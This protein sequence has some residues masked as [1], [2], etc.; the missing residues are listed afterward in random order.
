MA[1]TTYNAISTLLPDAWGAVMWYLQKNTFMPSIVQVFTDKSSD[2][3]RNG[4]KYAAGTAATLTEG[5]DISTPQTLSRSKFGSLVPTETGDM[6]VI[7]YNRLESDDTANIMTDLSTH[8]GN[9]MKTKIDTDLLGDMASMTAGTVGSAGGTLTWDSF[10]NAHA[11]AKATGIP[12]PYNCVLHEY[13]WNR[14]AKERANSVPLVIQNDLLNQSQF[15]VGSI[16]DTAFYT[17]GVLTA[18]TAVK[19]GLFSR[20]AIGYDIRRGVTI[21]MFEDISLRGYEVVFTHK[22]AHGV[23]RPDYGI[24]MIGDASLPS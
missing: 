8:I 24:Q 10:F 7:T 2:V 1:A 5:I 21:K 19:G 23:W 14:M 3:P 13:Q 22:Y 4:S 15:Y 16:G 18:G 6:F 9:T 17:T 11:I 20:Q 12:G